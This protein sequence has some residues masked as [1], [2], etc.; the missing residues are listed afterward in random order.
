M[1]AN[2]TAPLRHPVVRRGMFALLSQLDALAPETAK[3]VM[4]SPGFKAPHGLRI[5]LKSIR[6]VLKII[7]R[8]IGAL[9]SK[10][11]TG[12]V[13]QTNELM[14]QF[15]AEV[16]ESLQSKPPGK[17]QLQ[18]VL[19]AFPEFFPF[20]LNWVPETAAGIA[21]T[22]IITRLAKRWLEPDQLNALTLGIP[23]N[24][25]N[26]MNLAIGDLGDLGPLISSTAGAFWGSRR[27]WK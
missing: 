17:E 14:D 12:F 5:N 11:L 6:F 23:G 3:Q 26:E 20:F 16:T 8:V 7:R 13:D 1:F 21:S 24:V 22:R 9:F 2:L 25:V 4:K 15:I 27:R 18:A 19:D 10:D